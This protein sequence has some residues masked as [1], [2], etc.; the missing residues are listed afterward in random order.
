MIFG[1]NL[2]RFGGSVTQLWLELGE[3]Q[4]MAEV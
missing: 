3:L 2:C 4:R 1:V